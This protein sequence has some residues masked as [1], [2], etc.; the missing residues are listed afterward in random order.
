M[1]ARNRVTNL[2]LIAIVIGTTF[3]GYWGYSTA[4]KT[5]PD[6]WL[7]VVAGTAQAPIQYRVGLILPAYV[8]TRHT[9]LKFRHIFAAVDLGSGLVAVFTLA[10][11]LRRSTAYH[12]ADETT[13]WFAMAAFV[14]LVEFYFAWLM[15]Y[16]RPETLAASALL[17]LSLLLLTVGAPLR[18][19]AGYA[20][21][22][23]GQVMLAVMLALVRADV[24]FALH[25]GVLLMCLVNARVGNGFALPRW[26]QAS[27]S[28]LAVLASV[29]LQYYL[30]HVAYPGATYRDG[31]MFQL[32]VN[33]T[34]P[35]EWLAFGLF[36]MPF[37]WTVWTLVLRRGRG[38]GPATAV[39]AGALLFLCMWV[40]M[41]RLEEVR[42]FLPFALAL[43]PL[44]VGLAIER[45][46]PGPAVGST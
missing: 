10:F 17:A 37:G 36:L 27:T 22:A 28:F 4:Q 11:L 35:T 45:Y 20:I 3:L 21:T 38:E 8:V 14:V 43:A 34:S 29:G 1:Q 30:M 23:C 44:T 46:T 42:I 7:D 2:F 31:P 32:L 16:Q 12:N 25:A 41:G 24:P 13:R 19:V 6:I 33:L 5:N 15:W 39:L 26:V 9:S 18:G 40:V